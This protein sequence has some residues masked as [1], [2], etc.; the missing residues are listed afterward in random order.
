[1]SANISLC[2]LG[3]GGHRGADEVDDLT[4]ADLPDF[5]E[6][7]KSRSNSERKEEG[8]AQSGKSDERD[9]D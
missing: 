4:N 9:H 5:R 2:P 1:M 3:H 6:G 8:K 7:I